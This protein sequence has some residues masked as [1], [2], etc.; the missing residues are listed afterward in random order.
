VLEDDFAAR[1]VWTWRQDQDKVCEEWLIIRIEHNGDHSYTLSNAPADT[2]LECLAEGACGRY[3]VERVIQDGK[4]ETG[5]DEFQAQKY[6]GWEHHTAL[7]ACALWFI[8]QTKLAWAED[9]ARDPTLAHQLE[10]EVLPALSTANVRQMLKAVL[11]LQQ[12]SP[13]AAREQVIK[14]LVNRSR[15]TASR[16]KHKKRKIVKVQT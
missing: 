1:R 3:F 12:F 6:L 11:P 10:V 9:V 14:H 16:L 13:Q 8:A 15:S 4:D 5:W 2:A 7:T